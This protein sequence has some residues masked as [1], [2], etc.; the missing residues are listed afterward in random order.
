MFQGMPAQLPRLAKLLGAPPDQAEAT[1]IQALIDSKAPEAADLDYKRA[2]EYITGND[3]ADELA[4]DATGMANSHGGLILIGVEEDDQACPKNATPVEVNDKITGQ[5]WQILRSRIFPWLDGIDIHLV[6]LP[7]APGTGFYLIT[8][9]RSPLAPHAVRLTGGSKPRYAYAHRAGPHTRWLEEPEIANAYRNRFRLAEEHTTQ[10]RR[11][12]EENPVPNAERIGAEAT[13]AEVALIPA[14]PAEHRLDAAFID[15]IKTFLT[16]LA[17][18]S[19]TPELGSTSHLTIARRRIHIDTGQTFV[20]LHTDGSAFV[21]T[22]ASTWRPYGLSPTALP[23]WGVILEQK[24][25]GAVHLAAHYARWAGGYGDADILA[26][27]SGIGTVAFEEGASNSGTTGRNVVTR[28]S[29][30]PTQ[31]TAPLDAITDDPRQ[32]LLT[33]RSIAA[34]LL[35]DY[36]HPRTRLLNPDGSIAFDLLQNSGSLKT[37][38]AKS[39]LSS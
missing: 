35:A 37:W 6:R 34:D 12:F 3:G 9:P 2:N 29:N 28:T 16:E 31:I 32:L 27:T 4:K 23:I 17:T 1:H 20:D 10:A 30:E 39:G 24:T 38:A 11:L 13:W 22:C 21:R 25:L 8:V 5:M 14:V 15:A 33:A 26:R 36:G 7:D 18:T 19:P